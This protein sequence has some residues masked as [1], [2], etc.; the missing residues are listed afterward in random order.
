MQC[1]RHRGLGLFLFS[2]QHRSRLYGRRGHL[3]RLEQ[4]RNSVVSA[5][6]VVEL[7]CLLFQPRRLALQL[8]HFLVTL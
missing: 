5:I 3:F 8:R 7:H 4:H 1:H 2:D 6:L